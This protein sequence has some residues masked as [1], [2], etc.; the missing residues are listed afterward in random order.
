MIKDLS[1]RRRLPRAGIIRLGIKKKHP[2]TKNEYPV[3]TEFFV[4]PQMVKDLYGDEPK[5]LNIMFPVEDQDVFFQQFYKRYGHGILLCRGDGE[6]GKYWSFD[7]GKFK[8]QKCPCERLEKGDCKPVGVLQFIIPDIKEAV[9]VWQI[10]T[11]SKNSIIDVN[12]GLDMVRALAGRIAMIPLVLKRDLMETHRIEGKNIKK[13]KHYTLKLSLAISFFELQAYCQRPATKALLPPPDES[14][15]AVDDL[16]PEGGFKPKEPEEEPKQEVEKEEKKEAPIQGKR[17]KEWYEEEPKQKQ[18]KQEEEP[19]DSE[20][21]EQ[22]KQEVADDLKKARGELN[23]ILF[24]YLK[25]GG[26]VTEGQRKKMK[27]F[28]AFSDY[29]KAITFYTGKLE[30]LKKEEKEQNKREPGQEEVPFPTE[31]GTQ[32]K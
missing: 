6:N 28:K 3:E 8:E 26:K 1:D 29:S 15:K 13:G 32:K 27:E 18:E 24:V 17:K 19:M 5:E 14:Q 12:S 23:D 16:F 11:S 25:K 22:A 30:E 20:D 7:E 31:Q 2:T 4:C 10:S 21:Q 9:G